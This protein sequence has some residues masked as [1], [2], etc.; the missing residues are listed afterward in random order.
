MRSLLA[1]L[2][3]AL[4]ACAS[5]SPVPFAPP[6]EEPAPQSEAAVGAAP[7]DDEYYFKLIDRCPRPGSVDNPVPLVRAVNGLLP[8][9]K[10]R[11]LRI[12]RAYVEWK[13]PDPRPRGWDDYPSRVLWVTRLAFLTNKRQPPRCPLIGS[14][15]LEIEE[16]SD[17]W[18]LYPL[19]LMRDIPFDVSFGLMLAGTP[20][21]PQ[22]YL[23]YVEENAD[24]RSRA[25]RPADNPLKAVEELLDSDAWKDIDWEGDEP[26]H[27]WF[28][29]EDWIR[30]KVRQQVLNAL[31]GVYPEAEDLWAKQSYGRDY[32]WE[33]HLERVRQLNT[34]WDEAAQKYVA[35]Q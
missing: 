8:L 2:F 18:P 7:F 4:G 1:V 26:G 3:L 24:L 31:E 30:T 27:K 28:V 32:D 14:F 20:E 17:N 11:V 15:M 25:L 22:G 10:G 6:A 9:G 33:A 21:P 29:S 34:R 16:G 13:A 23:D 35:T 19:Q 12:L 5:K